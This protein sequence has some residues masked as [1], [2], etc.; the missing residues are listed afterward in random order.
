MCSFGKIKPKLYYF[1]SLLDCSDNC[2]KMADRMIEVFLN[3]NLL[4]QFIV[5][6][7]L[8][9]NSTVTR[10]QAHTLVYCLHRFC[11]T[12]GKVHTEKGL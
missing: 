10:W 6:F 1:H 5:S 9:S 4:Q 2:N 7:L 8:R 11:D 3:H 12:K